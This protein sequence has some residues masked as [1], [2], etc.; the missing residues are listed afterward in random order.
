MGLPVVGLPVIGFPVIVE[1]DRMDGLPLVSVCR[2]DAT[3]CVTYMPSSDIF[4]IQ[5]FFFGVQCF[6]YNHSTVKNQLEGN[7][8]PTNLDYIIY[9]TRLC[10]LLQLL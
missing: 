2:Y 10:T 5:R 1:G 3:K 6:F 9:N 4:A 8:Q 7:Q